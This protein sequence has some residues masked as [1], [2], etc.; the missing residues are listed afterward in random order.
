M[1][2]QTDPLH[3]SGHIAVSKRRQRYNGSWTI[4]WVCVECRKESK[5][6]TPVFR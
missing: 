2:I 3:G 5:T 4:G 6:W 1:C